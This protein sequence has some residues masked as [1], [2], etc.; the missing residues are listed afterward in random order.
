MDKIDIERSSNFITRRNPK[1]I[2]NTKKIISQRINQIV[3]K[4]DVSARILIINCT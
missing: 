1:N 3:K 4:L 2:E